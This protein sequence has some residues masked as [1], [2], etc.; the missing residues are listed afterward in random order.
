MKEAE[1]EKWKKNM[2]IAA[3]IAG[4]KDR[5]EELIKRGYEIGGE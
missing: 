4:D 2:T 1:M 5:R 3:W